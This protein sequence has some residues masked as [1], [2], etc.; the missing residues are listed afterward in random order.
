[1]DA[2]SGLNGERLL[3]NSS[4]FTNW[5]HPSISGS[6][7]YEAVVFPAP[8]HPDMTYSCGMAINFTVSVFQT[9][10]FRRPVS[11]TSFQALVADNIR[12]YGEFPVP[13]I[14]R[15]GFLVTGGC[16]GVASMPPCPLHRPNLVHG[17][18]SGVGVSVKM[19]WLALPGV[20]VKTFSAHVVAVFRLVV[21]RKRFSAHERTEK[22]A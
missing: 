11:D 6:S 19:S 21:R 8:L 10:C 18:N 4:E 14:A 17:G 3:A 22:W 1:M 5:L 9:S 20:H 2:A 15:G 16:S 13:A 7:A 12:R